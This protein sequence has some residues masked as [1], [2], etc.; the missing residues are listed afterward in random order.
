M[1]F[2]VKDA[3]HEPLYA[4]VP[5]F[6]PWRWK[7]RE[8]HTLRSIK[9]F[10][11]SGAVV[12]LVEAAYNRR[13]FAFADC[14]LDGAFASCGIHERD[15]RHK[16]VGLRTKDELWLKENLIN[17]GVER[18]PY[19][20]QNVAWL[21]S[22]VHFVRPNW[23]GETI[24][25]L[26]HYS[27]LQM[28]SHA[29]DLGPNYEM[30]DAAYPHS[31]GLSWMAAF[32]K[33]SIPPATPQGYYGGVG[34]VWPGLAWAC[35]R[36]AW[37]S[38]GGLIDFAIWGGADWHMAHALIEQSDSMMRNDLHPNYKA[39]VTGWAE[40]CKRH[41]RRN[42]GM[43][44]GSIIH[45]WHG[46][47]TERGYNAKHALLAKFGFDPLAHLK[48]DYQGLWQLHDDGTEA[49]VQLRDTLR[50]IAKERNE[51]SIDVFTPAELTKNH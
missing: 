39:L 47:K 51:D 4:I 22:D 25:K 41:I 34:A 49:F 12:V 16:Y 17:V 48:R 24:H 3:V 29:R 9:H 14:G 21:D 32:L 19:D 7:A 1:A 2:L 43:V 6:N 46:R 30:L 40:R 11:D 10:H 15:F 18:L 13:D 33:N 28:F 20:W 50:S 5:Y 37:D 8:K 35:T 36:Q 23:V 27:F 26:Q 44:E 38:V 45:N 42:V 31:N